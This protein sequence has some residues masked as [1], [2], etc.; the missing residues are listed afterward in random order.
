MTPPKP[1]I[2]PTRWRFQGQIQ[3]FFYVDPHILSVL[4][5]LVWNQTPNIEFQACRKRLIAT[6]EGAHREEP[7]PFYPRHTRE[8]WIGLRWDMDTL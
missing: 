7:R 6:A 8:K 5:C 4:L 2:V 1:G 3:T